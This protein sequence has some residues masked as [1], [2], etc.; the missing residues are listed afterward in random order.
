VRA[1]AV[2]LVYHTVL[3]QTYPTPLVKIIVGFPPGG[4]ADLSARLPA[5]ALTERL[6]QQFVVENRPVLRRLS[7]LKQ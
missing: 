3:A 1:V 6:K 7:R 5:Q 4:L 2:P